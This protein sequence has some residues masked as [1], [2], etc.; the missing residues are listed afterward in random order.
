MITF[1]FGLAEDISAVISG[2]YAGSKEK[3]IYGIFN[4]PVNAIGAS[5]ICAYSLNSIMEVFNGFFKE[6]ENFNSN[7]LRVPS[8]KVIIVLT[9]FTRRV[10]EY[11]RIYV[12]CSCNGVL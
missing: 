6:Q 1:S 4:T 12:A 3:L 10:R 5:A 9:R 2:E 11:A 8:Y 7:W